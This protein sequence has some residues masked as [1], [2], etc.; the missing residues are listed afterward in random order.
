VYEG[1]GFGNSLGIPDDLFILNPSHQKM[2]TGKR[3]YRYLWNRFGVAGLIVCLFIGLMFMIE[4]PEI[5][6]EFRLATSKTGQVQGQIIDHRVS[7]GSKSTSYYVTYKFTANEHN[8]TREAQVNSTEYHQ[9]E[10]S[11]TLTGDI[12]AE[13]S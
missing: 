6:T 2:M 7:Q 8:Y 9:Y 13:R 10:I 4:L 11:S 12:H 5:I 3:N 1:V